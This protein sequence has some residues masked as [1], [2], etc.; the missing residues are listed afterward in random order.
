M[1]FL[2][3]ALTAV[4]RLDNQAGILK[5]EIDKWPTATRDR[6]AM[7][8]LANGIDLKLATDF[9]LKPWQHF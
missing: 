8:L 5:Q 6:L 7:Y 1:G 9:K 4:E 2:N 3:D